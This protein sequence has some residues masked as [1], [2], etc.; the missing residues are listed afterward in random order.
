MMRYSLFAYRILLVSS[1]NFVSP[2]GFNSALCM[3]TYG[4]AVANST[5]IETL[6]TFWLFVW[7]KSATG[8]E[9]FIHFEKRFTSPHDAHIVRVFCVTALR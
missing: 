2:V 7:N 3:C 9:L 4:S 5:R 1:C 8:I 6:Q